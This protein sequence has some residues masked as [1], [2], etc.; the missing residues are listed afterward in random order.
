MLAFLGDYASDKERILAVQ[1][2]VQSLPPYNYA[3]AKRVIELC[4]KVAANSA[5]NRMSPSSLGE[6]DVTHLSAERELY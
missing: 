6:F 1:E 3:V 5:S 4:S 2:V